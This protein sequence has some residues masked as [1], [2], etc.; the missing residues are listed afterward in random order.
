MPARHSFWTALSA[1][2]GGLAAIVTATTG[3]YLALRHDSTPST[4]ANA[5]VLAPATAGLSAG[6]A[7]SAGGTMYDRTPWLG[8]ELRQ[9]DRPVRLRSVHEAWDRFESVVDGGPFEVIVSRRAEDSSIGILAWHDDSIFECV[10]GGELHLPGTGIAGAQFA[11]PILY[12]NKEG[13]NYYNTER[14]K[15]LRDDAYSVF[16][17]TIGVG[18]LELPLG[19]FAGPLHLIIFRVP[20]DMVVAARDFELITLHRP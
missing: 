7:A 14:M 9:N 17:S 2:L 12:L 4:P 20:P 10:R 18:E 5:A 3:L 16:I 19:R 11:V 8:V 1:V 15:R 13:F 6:P